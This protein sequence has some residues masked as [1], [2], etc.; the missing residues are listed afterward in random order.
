MNICSGQGSYHGNDSRSWHRG[1]TIGHYSD[2]EWLA[3][4]YF[5]AF[6]PRLDNGCGNVHRYL[7][8]FDVVHVG[9]AFWVRSGTPQ[10]WVPYTPKNVVQLDAA[11]HP[12]IWRSLAR[13]WYRRRG[14]HLQH[15]LD[16]DQ[17]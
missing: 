15:S 4:I 8:P 6:D 17:G 12:I 2:A 14:Q 7:D 1:Y 16:W 9:A 11:R 10:A 5:T 3:Q 13:A